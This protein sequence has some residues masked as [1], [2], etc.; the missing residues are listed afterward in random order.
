M[1]SLR[2]RVQALEDPL[3]GKRLPAWKDA[4]FKPWNRVIQHLG[5]TEAEA[6]AAYEAESGLMGDDNRILRVIIRK[7]GSRRNA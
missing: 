2:N 4:N 1:R 7:S 5:Q 6:V 3:G